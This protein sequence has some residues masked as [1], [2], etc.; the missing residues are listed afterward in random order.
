MPRVIGIDPGTVSIDL[1]G[2][3]DGTVFLDRSFP[4]AAAL[5]HPRAFLAVL[6]DAGPLDLIAGPSVYGLPLTRAR[7]A[8]EEDLRLA[9]LAAE[10][11]A[12]V[13]GGLRPWAR[14]LA[15]SGL[16]V[17]LPPGVIHLT[18]V[19]EQRKIT[20]V[21]MGTADKVCVA[22]LAIAAQAERS[23]R[24]LDQVSLVLL[25]LGGAFTAAIAVAG[26]KIV[27]GVGGSAGPLGFRA[28]GALDGEET[29]LAGAVPKAMLFTGGAASVAGWDAAAGVAPERFAPPAA[30]R[31]P[32]AWD[33]FVENAGKFATAI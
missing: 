19:P 32:V 16:P 31:E 17:V 20:R 25:E 8:T 28:A 3:E 9:F 29:Y 11:A 22:A 15:R 18:S 13:S 7:E 14:A 4:T 12:G 2:L 6:T 26:G 10:G 30:P 1:C 33:A 5:S 27:D 21:D 23:T 24:P